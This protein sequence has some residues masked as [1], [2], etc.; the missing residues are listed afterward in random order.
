MKPIFIIGCQRTG[1]TLLSSIL[2]QFSEIDIM[3]EMHMLEP[4]WIHK[5]LSYWIKKKV[6][7]FRND[8]NIP[9]LIELIYSK[10]LFGMFWKSIDL[11]KNILQYE[12]FKSDRTLKSIFQILLIENCKLHKKKVCGAKFPV[13]FSYINKL[14]EWFPSCKIIHATR[15]VRGIYS[16]QANKYILKPGF[17]KT[18]DVVNDSHTGSNIKTI[19]LKFKMFVFICLQF[20]WASIIHKRSKRLKNYKLVRYEDIVLKPEATLKDLC[21]FLE[22]D[23]KEDMLYPMVVNSTYVKAFESKK[24]F[25]KDLVYKWK[26]HISPLTARFLLFLN[27]WAMKT[28]GYKFPF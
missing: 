23:F 20:T 28:F 5:D 8:D 2:N 16:S 22:I 15:D 10:Q 6:G 4:S 7:D 19:I 18:S 24:G 17:S 12:I 3:Y 26:N 21:Q 9:K 14:V 13:H 11:N 1:S 25:N 27:K